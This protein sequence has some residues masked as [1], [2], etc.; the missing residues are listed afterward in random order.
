MNISPKRKNEEAQE[1]LKTKNRAVFEINQKRE[2]ILFHD[3]NPSWSQQKLAN[4]FTEKF[5]RKGKISLTTISSILKRRK[6]YLNAPN[7]VQISKKSKNH[8]LEKCLT[9]W[10]VNLLRKKALVTN[11]MIVDQAKKFGHLIGITDFTNFKLTVDCLDDLKRDYDLT[12]P[13]NK[14]NFFNYDD[15]ENSSFNGNSP[16][17]NDDRTSIKKETEADNLEIE[18]NKFGNGDSN[19]LNEIAELAKE[20][21]HNEKPNESYESN[22]ND[23]AMDRKKN[24]VILDLDAKRQIILF[25]DQNPSWSQKKIA[26]YFSEKFQ[27]KTKIARNTISTILSKRNVYLQTVNNEIKVFPRSPF[28]SQSNSPPRKSNDNNEIGNT[29]NNRK[30][31]LF[32]GNNQT[33][34]NYN[35]SIEE[36]IE[37]AKE[38]EYNET[39]NHSNDDDENDSENYETSSIK[40][41]PKVYS[42]SD[43]LIGIENIQGLLIQSD[44]LDEYDLEYISKLSSKLDLIN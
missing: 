7:T 15:F 19:Y 29:A 40:I 25:H 3:R 28:C 27:F 31:Y 2:I 20:S 37:L 43:A 32:S 42:K 26:D 35:L 41:E 34:E 36:I 6:Y 16:I 11:E 21:D 4:Y 30:E 5:Q 33:S 10:Y 14:I 13:S 9:L 39:I 24:R 12:Q 22:S 8:C 18:E 17:Y 1:S 44:M 23:E 38:S